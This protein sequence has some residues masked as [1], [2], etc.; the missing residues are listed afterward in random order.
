MWVESVWLVGKHDVIICL[1]Y[2]KGYG[3]F[4]GVCKVGFMKSSLQLF[5][6]VAPDVFKA[7]LGGVFISCGASHSMWSF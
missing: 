7:K 5:K 6:L 2:L 4:Y 3:W 1:S